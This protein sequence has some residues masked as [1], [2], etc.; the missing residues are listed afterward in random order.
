MKRLAAL[1]MLGLSALAA[2]ASAQHAVTL[3]AGGGWSTFGGDDAPG[4]QGISGLVLG[5]AYTLGVTETL[6]LQFG[7]QYV[8]KGS[9]TVDQG[10]GLAVETAYVEVPVL[11]RVS[12]P[13]ASH[14]AVHVDAGPVAGFEESCTVVLF[15][16]GLTGSEDCVDTESVDVGLLGGIGVHYTLSEGIGLVFDARYNLGLRSI[17]VEG[18]VKNRALLLQAGI[19]FFLGG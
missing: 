18:D 16:M 8:E 4:A 1:V 14:L 17:D 13:A 12:I 11:V 6:S 7:A 3:S 15:G 9:E 2:P 10:F 5:A 19:A